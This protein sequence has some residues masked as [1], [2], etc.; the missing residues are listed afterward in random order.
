MSAASTQETTYRFG[1]LRQNPL[2][3]DSRTSGSTKAL[4]SSGGQ[5]KTGQTHLP[6]DQVYFWPN[7]SAPCP[8]NP[9]TMYRFGKY[10]QNPLQKG[11]TLGGFVAAIKRK[12]RNTKN[13]SLGGS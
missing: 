3:F 5:N 6:S 4:P 12:K 8:G 7:F 1:K 13:H 11:T 10:R 9:Y 2:D